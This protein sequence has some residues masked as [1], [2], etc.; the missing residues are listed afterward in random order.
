MQVH[1]Y[2]S[3]VVNKEASL[4]QVSCLYF[5]DVLTENSEMGCFAKRQGSSLYCSAFISNVLTQQNLIL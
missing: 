4:I 2:E 3:T 5:I 1:I